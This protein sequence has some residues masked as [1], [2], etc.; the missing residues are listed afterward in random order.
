MHV[1]KTQ[2][3]ASSSPCSPPCSVAHY[4]TRFRSWEADAYICQLSDFAWGFNFYQLDLWDFCRSKWIFWDYRLL[5]CPFYS[6][7]SWGGILSLCRPGSRDPQLVPSCMA[8][9]RQGT[10]HLCW[11]HRPQQR[12]CRVSSCGIF[13]IFR[14]LVRDRGSGFLV[15]MAQQL[16][17]ENTASSCYSSPSNALICQLISLNE[18]FCFS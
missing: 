12:L 6:L 5:F 11:S 8:V 9:Q 4:H 10:E 16:C 3:W 13:G 14:L 15:G 17:P 18:P 2:G 7:A 1:W